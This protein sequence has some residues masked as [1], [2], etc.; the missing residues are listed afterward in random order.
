MPS[1]AETK[2]LAYPQDFLFDLVMDIEKYPEFVPWCVSSKIISR[3][4]NHTNAILS[5]GYKL[6]RE[7][8]LSK[9]YFKPSHKIDIEYKDGPFKYLYNKWIFERLDAQSTKVHFSVDFEFR[10]KLL[11][12]A[13]E[14]VFSKA[15]FKMVQSFEDRADYLSKTP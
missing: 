15:V 6:F 12:K 8:F 2:L 7:S 11:Q 1:H 9:V 3:S 5:I 4:D 14:P 13:I 10:S